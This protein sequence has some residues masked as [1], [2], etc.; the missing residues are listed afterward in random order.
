[1][2]VICHCKGKLVCKV[3]CVC[4]SCLFVSNLSDLLTARVASCIPRSQQLTE[5]NI[6]IKTQVVSNNPLPHQNMNLCFCTSFPVLPPSAVHVILSVHLK[7]AS[8]CCF[9]INSSKF[10]FAESHNVSFAHRSFCRPYLFYWP[11]NNCSPHVCDL[12]NTQFVSGF[13]SSW[14]VND[15]IVL[16]I[17]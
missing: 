6:L 17:W 14:A 9:V 1:M 11:S 2:S 3:W 15:V 5:C 7:T 4:T 10:C 12:R 13:A 16:C 8:A